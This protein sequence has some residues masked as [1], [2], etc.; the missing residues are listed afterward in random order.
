MITLDDPWIFRRFVFAV[1]PALLFFSVYFLERF[2]RHRIFLF[3][4]LAVLIA[5]NAVVSQRFVSISENEG[6]LPQV[7]KLSQKFGPDDLILVDRLASGSGYSLISEP[8]TSLFDRPA[9]YF[10]NA[11]DFKYINQERYKN[12]FLITSLGEENAWYNELIAEK[13]PENLVP[14]AN[15]FLGPSE[16]KWSPAQNIGIKDIAIVWKLK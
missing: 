11:D 2:F 14:V 15:N 9:V 8:L 1:F 6:L 7:E 16:K 12:I 3:F 13:R 10:F 4:S 5:A